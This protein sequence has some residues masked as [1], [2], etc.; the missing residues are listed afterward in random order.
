MDRHTSDGGDQQT[1]ILEETSHPTHNSPFEI[2][3]TFPHKTGQPVGS[4]SRLL[5]RLVESCGGKIRLP[6]FAE[7]Q[8]FRLGL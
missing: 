4:V 7:N 3:T 2:I 6:R 5:I 8:S 1:G